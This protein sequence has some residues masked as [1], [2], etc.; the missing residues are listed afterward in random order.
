MRHRLWIACVIATLLV[1]V[2]PATQARA[3]AVLSLLE[4]NPIFYGGQSAYEYV[5]DIYSDIQY[6]NYSL[7]DLD[8]TGLLN[9]HGTAFYD[10]WGAEA[11]GYPTWAGWTTYPSLGDQASTWTLNPAHPDPS[12]NLWHDPSE[13]VGDYNPGYGACNAWGDGAVATV[14][15]DG[16]DGL[17]FNYAMLLKTPEG[18]SQTLRLVHLDGPWGM[19]TFA[20]DDGHTNPVIGPGPNPADLDV[21]GDV[22]ADDIDILCANMGGDPATY[23]MDSDGD[24]DEDDMIYVIENLVELTDGVRV[25]TKRGD[26]NLDGFVDGTDLALMKVAFGQPGQTYADGNANCDLLVDGT[27]LAILKSNMGFIAPTGGS[28]GLATGGVPEPM[29]IGLLSLGGLAMLRRRR[30]IRK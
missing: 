17:K 3:G 6:F 7:R 10:K 19:L 9:L 8:T 29:T 23:D 4:V 2:L 22:D 28:A 25:G 5:Y 30:S 13:Y 24:V 14:A 18:L 21:D 12:L 15:A 27:D 26:F 1:G 11:A 16:Y 20:A